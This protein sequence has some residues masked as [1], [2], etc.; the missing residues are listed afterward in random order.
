MR[1]QE[2]KP[3]TNNATSSASLHAQDGHSSEPPSPPSH[4]NFSENTFNSSSPVLDVQLAIT[5]KMDI[6]E[7]TIDGEFDEGS[8]IP[9]PDWQ[10]EKS[11]M[12]DILDNDGP[13]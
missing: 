3:A 4:P 10:E 11:V 5:S 9:P 7:E 12:D 6:N 13:A 1:L 2:R 8:A